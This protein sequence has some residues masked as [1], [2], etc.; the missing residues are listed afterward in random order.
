MGDTVFTGILVS[1]LGVG[2]SFTSE[3]WAR[4][5]FMSH[6]GI[7]P[8][9]GTL[10]L[11]LEDADSLRIWAEISARPGILL[12]TPS[13]DWCNAKCFP[14][15]VA[16]REKGAIVLPE[17]ADYPADKIEIIAAVALRERLGLGEGELVEIQVTA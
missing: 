16:G 15:L 6:L 10:N 9:P 13:P 7:D 4:E 2:A 12:P 14:T 3:T 1:G 11:R 8:W 5:A 17:V